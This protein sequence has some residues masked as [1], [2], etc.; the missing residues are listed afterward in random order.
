MDDDDY[1]SGDRDGEDL[2]DGDMRKE[3][4]DIL[5]Q[6]VGFGDLVAAKKKSHVALT[7]QE[8]HQ[9]LS[10]EVAATAEVFGVPADWALALLSHY[11]WDPLRLHEEWFDK[12]DRILHA[13]GLGDAAAADAVPGDEIV[14]S[15]GICT[16]EK[17][18]AEMAS[19]GCAHRYCGECWRR[20][21]AAALDDGGGRCLALRCPDASCSR[22][23]L[24]GMVERFATGAGRD[25]YARAVA[26]AYVAARHL[27]FKPCTAAG[28]GCVIEL[29]RDNVDSDLACRCGNAFCWRCGGEPHWP[30][31]CA[32]AARWPRD[33]DEAS[34][35]WMLLHTKPCPLCR[36]S[37]ERIG[38]CDN[39]QCA[40]PC[41]HRFCWTCLAP[42]SGDGGYGWRR[43]K[44][45]QQPDPE[46]EEE[47]TRARLALERFLHYQDMWMDNLRWRRNAERE[48]SKVRD[49]KK[50]PRGIREVVAEAWEQVVEGRRVLGN[51]C[52]HG[53]WLQGA[54]DAARRELFD[55]QHGDTG[56]MLE[57]LQD[58]AVKGAAPKEPL[59][60]FGDK[61]AT[62]TLAARNGVENFAKAVEEGIPEVC[63]PAPSG[64][65]QG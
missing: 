50:L 32:A 65:A 25:A 59:E 1:W 42:V 43:C 7:E 12:Q 41:G 3:V 9:R 58:L 22:A 55:F 40:K 29:S 34:A 52:A 53:Q 35:G 60:V 30:A 44:H 16:E 24:R 37:I 63:A 21:V 10:Q 57:R 2:I 31:G 64:K 5:C 20:Y 56:A 19:P 38:G 36:R 48:L 23:V 11:R 51:A 13:V 46:T 6:L 61:L 49:D 28:C 39:M 54:D 8:I 17:P 15:C 47:L 26:R 27:W 14:A 4:I 45:D 33:A 18:V 62:L